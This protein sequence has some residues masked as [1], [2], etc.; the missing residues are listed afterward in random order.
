MRRA[1]GDRPDAIE[2]LLFD[3]ICQPA[4]LR[5]QAVDRPPMLDDNLVERFAAALDMR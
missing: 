1:G 2:F 4:E 5:L 3:G